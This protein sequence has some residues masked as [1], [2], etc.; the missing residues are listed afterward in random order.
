MFTITFP[1][2]STTIPWADHSYLGLAHLTQ[3]GERRGAGEEDWEEEKWDENLM[4]LLVR[5]FKRVSHDI[6]PH[7]LL[8]Q[9]T[10]IQFGLIQSIFA[11]IT[12]HYLHKHDHS[13]KYFGQNT[14]I[15]VLVLVSLALSFLPLRWEEGCP[16]RLVSV[17]KW[18]Q[19]DE[20]AVQCLANLSYCYHLWQRK[21][22]V[23]VALRNCPTWE[24]FSL[25]FFRTQRGKVYF[26][27]CLFFNPQ[28]VTVC[29]CIFSQS[30]SC[31]TMQTNSYSSCWKDTRGNSVAPRNG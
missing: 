17:I 30:R 11:N 25:K 2:Y 3:R 23:K 15:W 21:S 16:Q 19:G 22:K 4:F 20:S 5:S 14:W 6:W 29:F 7:V 13:R 1:N 18:S 28:I 31:D 10:L 27:C 8:I 12:K 24:A 9:F 26:S